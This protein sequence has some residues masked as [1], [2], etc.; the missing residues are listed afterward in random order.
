ML[1]G[2]DDGAPDLETALAMAR[3]AA[4]DG[5]TVTACTP[6]IMPGLYPNVGPEIRRAVAAFR[7]ELERQEIPLELTTGADVHL[8]PDLV[9]GLTEGRLLTLA[10]SRYFLFEPPHNVAPPR[11]EESVFAVMAAGYHPIVTHPER[12]RWIEERYETIRSVAR[13]GA[14]MQLTAGSV[15]GRF[16]KRAQYWS[17]RMPDEG[18]VHILATDAHNMRG[19]APRLAEAVEAVAARLG[20]EAAK[21]MVIARPSV[22][23]KNEPP[24]HAPAP[25]GAARE[26]ERSP[27]LR[28][29]ISSVF[30]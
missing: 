21:D 29:M 9:Q 28:R 10:D 6:H 14:W 18:L 23:L 11:F 4:A 26:I 27:L 16:G 25:V 20:E 7:T 5:V 3:A 8:V 30:R 12:L 17:E 1:P 22:V 15:T 13:A 2:V 24:H 19:R